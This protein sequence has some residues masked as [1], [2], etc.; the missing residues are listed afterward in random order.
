MWI[1]SNSQEV[2]VDFEQDRTKG[3]IPSKRDINTGN[4]LLDQ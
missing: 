1:Y 3:L 2:G 4:Q